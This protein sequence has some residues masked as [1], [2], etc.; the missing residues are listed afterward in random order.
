[1]IFEFFFK[2]IKTKKLNKDVELSNSKTLYI[3]ISRHLIY[4][5]VIYLN[6]LVL[7]TLLNKMTININMF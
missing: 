3:I 7:K 5:I 2:D 6:I 4:I 1:L